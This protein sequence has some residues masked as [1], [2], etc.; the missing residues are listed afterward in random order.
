MSNGRINPPVPA[1]YRVD[2]KGVAAF[3]SSRG[4]WWIDSHSGRLIDFYQRV[5]AKVARVV[6]FGPYVWSVLL[7]EGK[8]LI[9]RYHLSKSGSDSLDYI[10]DEVSEEILKGQ[11]PDF[12]NKRFIYYVLDDKVYCFPNKAVLGIPDIQTASLRKLLSQ[13]KFG[14]RN[15]RVLDFVKKAGNWYYDAYYFLSKTRLIIR[16]VEH[17]TVEDGCQKIEDLVFCFSYLGENEFEYKS[18][19]AELV[20]YD[21]YI[22]KDHRKLANFRFFS[23]QHVDYCLAYS[24]MN[25]QFSLACFSKYSFTQVLPWGYHFPT[26]FKLG[27]SPVSSEIEW[28]KKKNRE[29][30]IFYCMDWDKHTDRLRVAACWL[31]GPNPHLVVPYVTQLTL[32]ID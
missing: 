28:F 19:H 24:T 31:K 16:Y 18:R 22:S 4:D 11:V 13:S 21:R 17:K 10:R 29:A 8:V 25:G 3:I 20:D 14:A 15:V 27:N 7:Q 30:N 23:R 6:T 5:N 26:S 1:R 12:G 2:S 9:Q 32:R